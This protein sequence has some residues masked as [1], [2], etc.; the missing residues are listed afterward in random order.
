[1]I[2]C[3]GGGGQVTNSESERGVERVAEAP[4]WLDVPASFKMAWC[5]RKKSFLTH[6]WGNGA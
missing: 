5:K 4:K 1:M 2:K 6:L 3:V